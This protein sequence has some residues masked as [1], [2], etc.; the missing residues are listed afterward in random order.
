MNDLPVVG[1]A[2]VRKGFWD[3]QGANIASPLKEM[4]GKKLFCRQKRRFFREFDVV[5]L[6][7]YQKMGLDNVDT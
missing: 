1:S 7:F 3:R 2:V 5:S 6:P 4:Y